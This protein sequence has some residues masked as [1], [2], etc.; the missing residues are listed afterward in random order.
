M[1]SKSNIIFN[2]DNIKNDI[3]TIIEAKEYPTIIKAKYSDDL[4]I[5][6]MSHLSVLRSSVSLIAS[7]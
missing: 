1:L 6:K 3:P 5:L 4:N 7:L 2:I